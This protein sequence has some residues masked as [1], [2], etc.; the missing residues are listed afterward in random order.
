MERI[1]SK[2]T[3][4][5]RIEH[6]LYNAPRGLRVVDLAEQCGVD[7][8]TIY[9]DLGALHDMGV[10]VWEFEGRYG[11]ERESY[12]STIRL[13]LN[14][15]VALFFAARLLSHHSDEHNPHV[16][17]ALNK[18]AASLPDSTI[19][20]Y[21]ARVA[22][23]IR[24]RPMRATYLHVLETIT[25]A[26]ADRYA[27]EIRY[28]SASGEESERV[29]HPYVLE[30]SRSEPASYVVAYDNRRGAIRTFKLE[31]ITAITILDTVYTIPDDFD[32]YEMFA[33][34]WGVIDESEVDVRLLFAPSVT[35]R[36]KESVWHHSQQLIDQPDGG[37]EMRLRV[38]GIK[39]LRA[40]VLSWG[41]AVVV[42]EPDELREAVI[43]HAR[44]MLEQ[45]GVA[46]VHD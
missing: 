25:R 22:E 31:R 10:P 16:V 20:A 43:G 5:R 21:I 39:E 27:V 45:Y 37:C 40:W 9:R 3:R 2:A 28:R 7:R 11:I 13:N 12:L 30:V 17:S 35:P 8:R 34:S 15:A 33:A 41:S 46:D 23:L 18:L 29:I 19:P 32:P 26:W 4:L 42:V 36:V 14:E 1:Q 38:G 44:G 24:A 6:L